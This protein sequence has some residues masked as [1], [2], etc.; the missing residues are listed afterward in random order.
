MESKTTYS[1]EQRNK[2][3]KSAYW[4]LR[5]WVNGA[6]TPIVHTGKQYSYVAGIRERRYA[7][8]ER[9]SA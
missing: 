4:V 3:H 6:E 9:V 7:N 1:I 8:A 2:G 5:V